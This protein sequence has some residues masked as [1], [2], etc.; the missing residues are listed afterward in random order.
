MLFNSYVFTLA[1]LPLAFLF[2]WYGGRSLRWRLG[3]LT[4]AS[5]VFYSWWQ[6]TD[7][8]DLVARFKST[9]LG[10]F[11]QQPLA[12]AF[13]AH[14]VGQQQHRLLGGQMDRPHPGQ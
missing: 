7:W 1:F 13:Y 2:F 5:Y 3:F 6:F 12:L 4:T 9:T 11:A 10:Q 8:Q 14:H